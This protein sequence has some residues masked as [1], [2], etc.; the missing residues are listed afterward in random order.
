MQPNL[1]QP[2]AMSP[3]RM[4]FENDYKN[5]GIEYVLKKYG[6]TNKP[7]KI[8]EIIRK[9]KWNITHRILKR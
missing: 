3:Q 7:G 2:S 5:R 6:K 9:I 1:Q 8:T 4:D